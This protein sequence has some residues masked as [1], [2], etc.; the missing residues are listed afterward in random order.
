MLNFEAGEKQNAVVDVLGMALDDRGLFSSFKQRLE[1][2]R[3][4]VGGS[5]RYVKWTRTLAL[6]A[7]IYQVRVA[8]RDR[9]TA[10][11]GSAMLWIEIPASTTGK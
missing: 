6:P 5:N 3:A 2:P 4:A 9:E 1:I 11:T 8:V 7:G 10:R